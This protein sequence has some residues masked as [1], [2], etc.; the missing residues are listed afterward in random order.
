MPELRMKTPE[1]I[2][3]LRLRSLAKQNAI[4]ATHSVCEKL[5][6]ERFQFIRSC[7]AEGN[8]ATLQTCSDPLELHAFASNWNC[9]RGVEPILEIVRHRACDAGTAL[10]LYWGND[11][12]YYTRYAAIGDVSDE[13]ERVILDLLRT[14]EHRIAAQDFATSSVPFDPQAW[15]EAKYHNATWAVRKIPETMFSA[16]VPTKEF[17]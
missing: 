9:D 13:D 8:T 14:I 2:A 6:A 5:S 12:Y 10:W 7:A 4:R 11:P 3:E 15:I 16:I 17:T 1:E